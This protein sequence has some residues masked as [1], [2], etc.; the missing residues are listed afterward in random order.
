MNRIASAIVVSM[1]AITDSVAS[2]FAPR[3]VGSIMDTFSKAVVRLEK[4]ADRKYSQADIADNRI[5]D[6]ETDIATLTMKSMALDCEAEEALAA[7]DR[8][9]ALIGPVA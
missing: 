2:L 3:S 9:R 1:S 6:L 5:L 4:L 7:A 8:V